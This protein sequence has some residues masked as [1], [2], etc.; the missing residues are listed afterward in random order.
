M[1]LLKGFRFLL[2]PTPVQR[3]SFACAAG[4]ARLVWNTALALQLQRRQHQQPLLSYR[5]LSPL[6]KLWKHEKPFLKQA[7][8]QA[9]QQ[10]LM[11]LSQ[12]IEEA[13]D[14]KNSK[15]FPVFK[16]KGEDDSFRYPQHFEVDEQR[17]KIELPKLGWVRY[18]KS[19]EITGIVKNVTLTQEAGRWYVS[20]QTEQEIKEPTHPSSSMIAGDLGVVHFL[21]LSDGTHYDAPEYRPLEEKRKQ[22]QRK[23]S[24]KRKGGKNYQ[25]QRIKLQRA[26]KK[27]RD[28]REDFQHQLSY[29][30]SKEAVALSA[31]PSE[32]AVACLRARGLR[33]NH[34]VV[35]LEKLRVKGMTK[36][37]KGTIEEPGKNVAQKVGLNRAILRQAWSEFARQVKYKCEWRGARF[38]LVSPE[39]TSQCC[40]ACGF[41]SA[42]NRKSQAE[43]E[44]ISCGHAENADTNAAKNAVAFGHRQMQAS[45][46]SFACI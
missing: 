19:Q 40:S 38:I 25:K 35:V 34:A 42:E 24:K 45:G 11:D 13:R 31:A 29:N 30:L 18:V 41:V 37:A 22:E 12:A 4:C 26:N 32:H 3:H 5:E 39:Y 46:S 1:L 23:L 10:R 36:S 44:C 15:Q 7:P 20:L 33:K 27:V 43:F 16:K 17:A 9:L 14:P 6:L 2:L 8:S 21:T 28:K